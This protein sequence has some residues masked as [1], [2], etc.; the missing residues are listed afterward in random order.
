VTLG[1]KRRRLGAATLLAGVVA[2]LLPGPAAAAGPPVIGEVWASSVFSGSARLHAQINPNGLSTGY[3]VD[4][5]PKALYDANLG[6][7][8]DPFSGTQRTPAVSEA[9]I[10][11]ASAPVTTQQQPFLAP[12]TIYRYRFVAKNSAATVTSATFTVSTQPVAT[13][14]LSD[15]RGWEMVSPVDKNGGEVNL[16]GTLAGGGVL[17]AAVDGQSVTYGSAT[18]FG[19]GAVGA[20]TASQYLATRLSGGWA[21]QNI[22]TPLYSGSYNTEDE[23]VPYQLFSG[24]LARGLLLNGRHCR[25][26]G[27]GC[28]VP[29][30]PLAGTDAPA[31]YQNYYLREGASYT[32]LLGSANAGFLDLEPSDLELRLAG[33]SSD[34]RQ[35][36]ISTCA[37]LTPDATE[38]PL[39]GSCDPA[40]PNLYRYAPGA[41]LSLVNV[42]PAQAMGAPGASLGAQ[43]GAISADG[44]RVYFA[45]GGN[46]YLREG[47]LTKQVDEAAGGGGSFQTASADGSVAYFTKGDRLWRFEAAGAGSATDLTPG[48]GAQGVLGASASGS[49][50]YY[51]TASGLFLWSAGTTTKVADSADATNYPPT[52]GTSRVSA[53]GTQVLFV[54]TQP[55]GGYD[56]EDLSTGALD[57]QVYLYDSA[58]AGTLTCA[59][60]NPTFGRPIGPSSIPGAIANGTAPGSTEAYKPRVLAADGRRVFF[61]SLDAV[62]ALDTTG[63]RDVYQWQAQGSGSCT[64]PGGCVNLI[65]SGKAEGGARF[66]DASAS[67]ADAFFLTD[68]SLVASDP[69]GVDLYDARIG[70]GFTV[71]QPPLACLGDACQPLPP[72]PVNPT[73]TTLLAGP[74]NPAVR[75]P[76]VSKRCKQGYVKRKGKCV[77][78]KVRGKN[79]KS[80]KGGSK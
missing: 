70:G 22:T 48:G 5:I 74:G 3:H 21:T 43:A 54:A 18:S 38:V 66:L 64:R 42:L 31:G 2:V 79:A 35:A 13:T 50:V 68:G 28:A 24:D 14:L 41:G 33:T 26:E 37:A 27:V 73:L 29:N 67:G 72:E 49:H 4:Y 60:C 57:S 34:L 32:A 59:S 47:S 9:S 12:D 46:L 45:Q 17:Q 11:S 40:Q 16:P 53:D 78:K 71:P 80:G 58:G 55:L 39:G 20:A 65:S 76:E 1:Q 8:K 25:G 6:A 7:A 52:T 61:E 62:A 44:S 69:G 77:K 19:P 56:N 10:G 51:L 15:G 63:K 75:Y 36:V 23:G 30:P